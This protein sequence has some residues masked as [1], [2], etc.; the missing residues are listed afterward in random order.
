MYNNAY[1]AGFTPQMTRER[2]ENQIAELEKMK[3]QIPQNNQT[4][5]INQTFQLAPNNHNTMKMVNS[6]E[7][8]NKE[9]VYGDTP[10]FSKDLSVMWLKNAKGEIKSYELNEIVQKDDKD[11]MIESL[12]LQL[13]EMK[14]M[15]ED[16]KSINVNADEPVENKES[17]TSSTVRKSKAKSK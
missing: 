17:S 12:Q 15:I 14:G 9:V 6:I 11:L 13:N 8:V 7:D 10:F 4:P 2:I 3:A 16:A 1:M 5:A